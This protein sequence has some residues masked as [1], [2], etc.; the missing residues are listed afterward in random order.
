MILISS[1]VILSFFLEGFV[2]NIVGINT[3][4]FVPL[5]SI[6]SLLIVYP[7]FN[8]EEGDFLKCCFALGLAY[9]L[10][11]TDTLIVNACL[12]VVVGL[13]I[14]FLNSWLSNHMISI[15][16]MIVL[17]ILMYRIMMYMI[18]I[19]IG[20]LPLDWNVFVKSF[21]SS[22]LLNIIYGEVLY[23][24]AD[25]FSKKYHIRKID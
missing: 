1:V 12:F 8:H 3:N 21:Y 9:D 16:F 6:V 22:L 13:F 4:F 10:V 2:S 25:F 14:R 7:Y 20:F 17:T 18:L 24:S 19:V 5:F 11:Y 23:V 15:S